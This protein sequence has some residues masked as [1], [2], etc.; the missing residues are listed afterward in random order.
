MGL[1]TR[2]NVPSSQRRLAI[3]L[4]ASWLIMVALGLA[5]TPS[6]FS[7]P[8]QNILALAK[9]RNPV[10]YLMNMVGQPKLLL[11]LRS[12]GFTAFPS[13]LAVDSGNGGHWYAAF[14][15]T[16]KESHFYA[17]DFEGKVSS[18]VT[19][20]NAYL[21]GNFVRDP[22]DGSV[23]TIALGATLPKPPRYDLL[24]FDPATGVT[25]TKYSFPANVVP[26][27]YNCPLALDSHKRVLY[28]P[29]LSQNVPNMLVFS[30]PT[31]A[32]HQI[33]INSTLR[34]IHAMVADVHDGNFYFSSYY[35]GSDWL[36][37]YNLESNT[38]NYLWENADDV[39]YCV[40][41]VF[42]ANTSSLVSVCGRRLVSIQLQTGS[43][44]TVPVG[45]YDIQAIALAK[46]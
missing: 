31:F 28:A 33:A 42:D 24:K 44:K 2:S 4:R 46:M 19:I 25:T 13:G 9:I 26:S 43:T 39:H 16:L 29:V 11:D 7:T 5:L 30:L 15:T 23:Y 10:L 20:P 6:A 14:A 1:L 17:L 8:T 18:N 34:V 12:L 35:K 21:W 41:S 40:S 37:H 38:A 22:L 45:E 27:L 32:V 3:V 36:V